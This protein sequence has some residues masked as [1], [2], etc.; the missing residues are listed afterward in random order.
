MQSMYDDGDNADNVSNGIE[1]YEVI[2]KMKQGNIND[3]DSI[4]PECV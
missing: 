3:S 1:W 4:R 2:V